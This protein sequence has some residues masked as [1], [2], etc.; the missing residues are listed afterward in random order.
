MLNIVLFG[1]PGAGKGTHSIK[2]VEKYELVHFSTG[3]ILRGEIAAKTE[4][5]IQA[6]AVMDKG[7]LVPDKL[8]V[9]MMRKKIS[10]YRNSKGMVFDGFPRTTAQAEALDKLL[11]DN[12]IGI[13][14]MI[15]LD[16]EREE[17][18]K[19][20]KKRAETSG[21]TDDADMSIIENRIDVYNKQTLPIVEYYQKQNKYKKV[22]GIGSIEDIFGRIE[23]VIKNL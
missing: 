9:E 5:G 22:D 1:P 17:L 10:Q 4:L 16:V 20:L 21:R 18:I 23:E 3:E 13:D 12:E 6:K 8:V 15:M 7:E 2:L 19:R 11:L 14:A